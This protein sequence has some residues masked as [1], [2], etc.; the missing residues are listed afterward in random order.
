MEG[1]LLEAL[2]REQVCDRLDRAA[3]A[4]LA[5]LARSARRRRARRSLPPAR[6]LAGALAFWRLDS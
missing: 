6:I 2:A 3:A 1:L 5:R 4:R